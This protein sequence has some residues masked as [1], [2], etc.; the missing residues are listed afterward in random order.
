MKKQFSK[1]PKLFEVGTRYITTSPRG[2][3]I[4][5][6]T[7][8][9]KSDNTSHKMVEFELTLIQTRRENTSQSHKVSLS[10]FTRLIQD[11]EVYKKAIV[12]TTYF[13]PH[14]RKHGTA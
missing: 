8:V 12:D 4:R 13:E 11:A 14:S 10:E 6:I 7:K 2:V 5:E 1:S 3:S 9:H